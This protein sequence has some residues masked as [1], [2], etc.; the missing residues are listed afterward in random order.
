MSIVHFYHP[1]MLFGLTLVPVLAVLFIRAGRKRRLAAAAFGKGASLVSRRR[2]AIGCCLAVALSVLALAR[3]SWTREKQ[4]LQH[5]GRDLVF[6]LDVSRSMLAED[7]HPNRLESA[8]TAILDGVDELAGD[9]VGLVLFAGSAEIRCPMTLDYDYFRMALRQAAPESI[10]AGGTV[11]ANA[12]EK[13]VEKLLDP[14]KAGLQDVILITDGEDMGGE[15][16]V[17]EAARKLHDA[18]AR[19]IAIG[20]GDRIHG[21][22][23]AVDDDGE[24]GRSFLQHGNREVWTKL[25]AETLSNMAAAAPGGVY[26][27]V[28]DGPFD[29]R[30]IY[31]RVMED[32]ERAPTEQY[33]VERYEEHFSAFIAA[34]V[35]V[36]LISHRWSLGAVRMLALFLCIAGTVTAGPERLFEE[37][38]KAYAEG[39]YE[40]AADA[41]RSAAEEMDGSAEVLYNLGTAEYRLARF[42]EAAFA[43]GAAAALT[44]DE[45]LHAKCRYNMANC[46]VQTARKLRVE[47]PLSAIEQCQQAA[48]LYREAFARSPAFDNAAFNLE[49]CQRL[50]AAIA[51]EVYN[52]QDQQQQQNELIKYIHDKLQ[53][54]IERQTMLIDHPDAVEAQQILE[55][56]VRDLTDIMADS[57]LHSDISLPDGTTIPG[58]L[59]I[60][61]VHAG[62]AADAM[63]VPDQ[64]AALAELIAA[65]DA[66]PSVPDPGSDAAPSDDDT[67]S[68]EPSDQDA[69]M[70]DEADPFGDFSEYEDI[71]GVPPPNRTEADILTE[72]LRNQERRKQSREGAYKAVEKDW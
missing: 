36:L 66:A 62:L 50:A 69:D 10:A 32:A 43:F 67:M 19:L 1:E 72:E 48:V 71:R 38:N 21:G 65:L 61:F 12:L 58:P 42:D 53:E 6:V 64:P 13:T 44:T 60:T 34:A 26:A 18:G 22:R 33:T 56:E 15:T 47:E 27:E 20:I 54:F 63:A 25:H 11:I 3:P 28:A 30:Q 46:L 31:R 7:L 41:Y 9:R 70:Y 14:E 29:L 68:Y 39:R 51:E 23:I 8:K 49:I 57:G 4:R 52:Q 55:N 17:Y 37:G 2:E 5:R 59:K 24:G 45:S 40:A 35:F 16:A